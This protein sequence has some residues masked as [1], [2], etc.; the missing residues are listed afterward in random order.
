MLQPDR[1]AY[2][3]KFNYVEI[4]EVNKSIQCPIYCEAEHIH[5]VHY[6]GKGCRMLVN[7]KYIKCNHM[8]IER[9]K[10]HEYKKIML[11]VDEY[12][13]PSDKNIFTKK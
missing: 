5:K 11:I 8:M 13:L 2:V 1:I 7:G 4:Y 9:P 6:K 3:D 12:G 10:K